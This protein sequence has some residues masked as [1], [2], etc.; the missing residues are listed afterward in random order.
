MQLPLYVKH[1]A[2]AAGVQVWFAN[3]VITKLWNSERG[4]QPITFGGWYWHQK[5]GRRVVSTDDEGPFRS[6]SAAWRDAWKKLQ[7][8]TE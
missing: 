5:K 3:R 7:L 2:K 4:D 1:A 8:R 6:E